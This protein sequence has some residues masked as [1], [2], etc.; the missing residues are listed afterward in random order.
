MDAALKSID[1]IT[2]LQGKLLDYSLQA[3]TIGK[4]AIREGV[5]TVELFIGSARSMP[6]IVHN[7]RATSPASGD[8]R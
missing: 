1:R 7:I 6:V 4:D 3:I 2:G 5:R 8:C